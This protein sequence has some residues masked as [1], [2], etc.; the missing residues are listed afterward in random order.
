MDV[1]W[2][3]TF[4]S[5]SLRLLED[6]KLVL[7]D[8]DVVEVQASPQRAEETRTASPAGPHLD[9]V[10]HA[11]A[12]LPLVDASLGGTP[13]WGQRDTPASWGPAANR[14]HGKSSRNGTVGQTDLLQGRSAAAGRRG[15]TAAR[16]GP[17][18][19]CPGPAGG[20]P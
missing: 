18:R 3:R 19:A 10:S 1:A 11:A 9:Q 16:A 13:T 2:K 6:L 5:M 8:Q 7:E 17:G 14:S 12:Q 4:W 15:D 20:R